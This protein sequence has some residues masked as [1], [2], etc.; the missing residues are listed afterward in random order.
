[1]CAQREERGSALCVPSLHDVMSQSE[2]T[3]NY[4]G[5]FRAKLIFTMFGG[6]IKT[7][8]RG[9]REPK[10]LLLLRLQAGAE[11]WQ[12]GDIYWTIVPNI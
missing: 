9:L 6:V 10:L 11:K 2:L 12:G 7:V 3:T 8:Y 4:F 1:M 5:C